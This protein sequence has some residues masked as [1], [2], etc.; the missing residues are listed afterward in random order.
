[1]RPGEVRAEGNGFRLRLVPGACDGAEVRT[2]AR[3]HFG[4]YTMRMKVP[5]APGSISAFFLYADVRGGNDEIDIEILN[6][7]T[8]TALLTTW[9]AGRKTHELKVRLDFDPASAFHDYAIRWSRSVLRLEADGMPLAV[10]RQDVPANPMKVMANVWW[11][12]WTDCAPPS[13]AV[14]LEIQSVV[15]GGR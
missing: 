9:I 10:L 13:S 5:R 4:E 11:P 7:T 3:Y 12:V 14:A 15:L 6:D 2:I 8:R 1:M